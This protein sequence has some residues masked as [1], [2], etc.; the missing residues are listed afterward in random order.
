[1]L[2]EH[3]VGGWIPVADHDGFDE[4]GEW[5]YWHEWRHLDGRE[6]FVGRDGRCTD[7]ELEKLLNAEARTFPPRRRRWLLIAMAALLRR[8]IRLR[9]RLRSAGVAIA[10]CSAPVN[11]SHESAQ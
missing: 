1:M 5:T 9:R 4:N 3:S 11:N 6:A 7:P 10:A 8:F 2:L